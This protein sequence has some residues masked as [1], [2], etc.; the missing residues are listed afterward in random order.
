VEWRDTLAIGAW[1]DA[2]TEVTAAGTTAA[3]D[4]PAG[5]GGQRWFR[6]ITLP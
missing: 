4:A 2:G 1:T 5:T 6:V 3:F